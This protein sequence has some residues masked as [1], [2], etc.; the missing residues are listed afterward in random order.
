MRNKR[1]KKIKREQNNQQPTGM[2]KEQKRLHEGS[3]FNEKEKTLSLIAWC[4]NDEI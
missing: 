2:M 3:V 1:E 4:F